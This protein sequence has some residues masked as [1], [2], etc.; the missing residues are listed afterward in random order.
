MNPLDKALPDF[1]TKPAAARAHLRKHMPHATADPDHPERAAPALDGPHGC[2]EG[3]LYNKAGAAY[4][5]S[6]CDADAETMR[7]EHEI[8]TTGVGER[9]WT[10]T[11]ADLEMLEPF[12]Q[13]HTASSRITE[14]LDAGHHLLL[15][16]P[17]SC[18]K[19]QAAV[20][21]IRATLQAHRTA[22]LLNLGRVGM[23]IREGYKTDAGLTEAHVVRKAARPDLLILDDLGAGETD[24]AKVEQRLL[25]LILEERQNMRRSTILTTNLA[26]QELAERLGQ[27]L[28]GR[29]Q[30][31]ATIA[32][33][34]GRNFR[35]PSGKTAWE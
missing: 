9:Y 22:H 33:R 10:T 1:T 3:W 25:Y 2:S 12:P 34:H 27:R 29:L 11:W 15:S 18:G 21:L 13:L 31:L 26:P 30:P 35:R 16:G 20:L 7:V 28:L 24:A 14:I 23:E 8:R 5:C 32:F 6:Q 17:P 4:R 19:T